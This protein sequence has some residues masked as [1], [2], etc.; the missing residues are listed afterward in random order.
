MAG[1]FKGRGFDITQF[2]NVIGLSKT[3]RP[4]FEIGKGKAKAD[5]G[6]ITSGL[7]MF[8]RTPVFKTCEEDK[9]I[10]MWYLR[11]RAKEKMSNSVF[12]LYQL[13]KLY[14]ID[15]DKSFVCFSFSQ[16]AVQFSSCALGREHNA[17]HIG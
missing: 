5:V 4:S 11:L 9:K 3:Y 13:K 2:R 17:R 12:S 1:I 14:I 8:E 6:A 16:S 7:D 10:G 15:T